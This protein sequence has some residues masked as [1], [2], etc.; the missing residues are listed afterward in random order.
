V[1]LGDVFDG[2]VDDLMAVSSS[3]AYAGPDKPAARH[4]AAAI[5]TGRPPKLIASGHNQP[6][7]LGR[8]P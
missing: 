6:H 1:P 3:I 7:V 5:E 4:S 8:H 2:A